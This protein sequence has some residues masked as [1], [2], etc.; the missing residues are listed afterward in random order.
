MKLPPLPPSRVPDKKSE[1][2]ISTLPL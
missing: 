1:M 2:N